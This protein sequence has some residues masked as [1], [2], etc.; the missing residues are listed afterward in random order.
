MNREIAG[1]A[2]EGITEFARVNQRMHKK[3][4][5]VD[6]RAV[7]LGGRN[8]GDEYMGLNAKFNFHDLDVLGIGPV[9]RQT[10]AVFDTYW[11]SDWVMPA[12]ALQIAFSAAEQAANR[13]QPIQRLSK[14]ESLD[15]FP[16]APHSWSSELVALHSKLHIGTSQV[17]S[18]LPSDGAVR[19]ASRCTN[20]AAGF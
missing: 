16:L 3:A 18:D 4:L 13:A 10:S 2:G 20:P 1:R 7:I 8:I 5:I 15:R 6:N 11:N 9:A 17:Y 14:A 12:S 19:D